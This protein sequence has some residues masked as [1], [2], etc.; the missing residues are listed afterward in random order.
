MLISRALR[1]SINQVRYVTPVRVG[2]AGQLVGAVYA[3]IERDFG[4][5][6]PPNALHSPAPGPLAASWM[7][8]RET[9]LVSDHVDRATKEVVAAVVSRDNACPYCVA[10]HTAT[11][12]GISYSRD[13]LDTTD[14]PALRAV[15]EWTH[16]GSTEQTAFDRGTPFPAEQAPELIG[17]AVTFQYLNRMV[18]IFLNES[19]LPPAVPGGMRAGAMRVLGGFMRT[20]ANRHHQPG[21]SLDLQPAAALPADLSWA[22]DNSNIA[23]AFARAAAAIDVAGVRTVPAAV[24]DLVAA[25]L[26]V[27]QGQPRG[28][29]R[30]WLTDAVAGLSDVDRP[31]G[32][33]ALLTAFAAYQV[34]ETVVA[35]FR[36]SRPSDESLI[37]LTSWASMAAA[38][39]VGS[40]LATRRLTAKDD[41]A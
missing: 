2:R 14:D 18:Q 37:E 1:N 41:A 20:S 22:A 38:R 24:R 25:E 34:D 8:L 9:L 3:Q 17:V 4:M 16:A 26:A 40:W 27:W 11:L 6:A 33:L 5:L 19:P 7:M 10:I 36:V 12:D 15:A 21:A 13:V 28:I 30:G 35:E 32:R 23:N 39:R 31:A 29:G